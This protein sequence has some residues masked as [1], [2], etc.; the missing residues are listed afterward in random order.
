MAEQHPCS[1]DPLDT[2]DVARCMTCGDLL[3]VDGKWIKPG[4]LCECCGN[5]VCL[6]CPAQPAEGPIIEAFC[7]NC[8]AP[9]FKGETHVCDC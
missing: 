4:R 8:G 3:I 2:I 7:E 1:S 9:L 6:G 5:P